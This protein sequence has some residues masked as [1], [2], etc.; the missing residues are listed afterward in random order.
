MFF[1]PLTA[2]ATQSVQQMKLLDTSL[3]VI[4]CMLIA[5]IALSLVLKMLQVLDDM[6]NVLA[7]VCYSPDA[8]HLSFRRI[9]SQMSG[10]PVQPLLRIDWGIWKDSTSSDSSLALSVLDLSSSDTSWIAHTP[11]Y[12]LYTM[13]LLQSS[14]RIVLNAFCPPLFYLAVCA[15]C[16]WTCSLL[17]FS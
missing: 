4:V 14:L 6:P 16:T 2:A 1:H 5:K 17:Y 7:G 11:L 12:L 13:L 10:I 15:M 3:T 8:T 9:I